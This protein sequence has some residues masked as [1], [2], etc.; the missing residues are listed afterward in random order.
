MN[1]LVSRVFYMCVASVIS[2]HIKATVKRAQILR[3][4]K[5]SIPMRRGIY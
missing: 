4:E 5:I 1:P 2:S 3:K